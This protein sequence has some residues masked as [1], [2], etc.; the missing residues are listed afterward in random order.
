MR[1]VRAVPRHP[2]TLALIVLL[3]I[4]LAATQPLSAPGPGGECAG[5][6][7]A[8]RSFVRTELY[9]GLGRGDG[10]VG[11]AEFESFLAAEVAPRFPAGLTLVDGAGRFEG[12]AGDHV[13]EQSKL[14][15]LLYPEAEPEADARIE[16][17][18]REY[19]RRFDQEAVLRSDARACVSP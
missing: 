5:A 15:I 19:R 12:T 6:G 2:G 17:I 9:F 11:G 8:S 4:G 1:A 7:Q 3:G 14:L 13:V 16:S 18:R 10:V